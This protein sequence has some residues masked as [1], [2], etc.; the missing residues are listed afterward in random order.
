MIG[1]NFIIRGL[2]R[3]YVGSLLKGYEAVC[4]EFWP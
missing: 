3:K 4:K 1:A 2:Y